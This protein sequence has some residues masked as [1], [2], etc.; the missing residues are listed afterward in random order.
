M[1]IL[2]RGNQAGKGVQCHFLLHS[3]MYI[4]LIQ[5]RTFSTFKAISQIYPSKVKKNFLICFVRIFYCYLI[6]QIYDRYYIK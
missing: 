5:E 1:V 3:R 4:L 2:T 6:I